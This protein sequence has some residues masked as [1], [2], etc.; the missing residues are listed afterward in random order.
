M[1]R[2]VIP[3]K[4]LSARRKSGRYNTTETPNSRPE[5]RW[6]NEGFVASANSRKPAYDDMNL[7]QWAVAQLNNVLQI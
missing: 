6:P 3:G 5:G 7:Q 4:P 1:Q 2:E